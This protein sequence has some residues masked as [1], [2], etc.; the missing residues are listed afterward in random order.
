MAVIASKDKLIDTLHKLLWT[1]I[2][3]L[4]FYY[5]NVWDRCQIVSDKRTDS[6]FLEWQ[7]CHYSAEGSSKT[8]AYNKKLGCLMANFSFSSYQKH[9]FICKNGLVVIVYF[10]ADKLKYSTCQFV[11]EFYKS[12][13]LWKVAGGW[14]KYH[15]KVKCC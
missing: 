5:K 1:L 10:F 15:N 7:P 8:I 11:L 13:A 9:V 2:L 6:L 4:L 12:G 14:H 3:L